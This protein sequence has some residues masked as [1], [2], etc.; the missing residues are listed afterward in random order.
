MFALNFYSEMYMDMLVKGRKTATIRLGDKSDK[1]RSGQLIWI[2]VGRRFGPRQKLFAAIVD[3]VDVKAAGELNARE[4]EKENP[5]LRL[6]DDVLNLLGRIYDRPVT[7]LDTV[8]V[9]HFSQVWE[10]E[11][12]V[13]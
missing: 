9:I 11:V 10:D 2:T 13:K 8:T 5:E 3:E 4:I 1:Y 12:P 7:P 6:V